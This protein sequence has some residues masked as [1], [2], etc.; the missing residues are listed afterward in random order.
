M[1]YN[2][3][4]SHFAGIANFG[5]RSDRSILISIPILLIC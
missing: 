3:N 4:L 5:T 1:I 2:I